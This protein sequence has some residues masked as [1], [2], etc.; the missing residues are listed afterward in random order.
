MA[1]G[2]ARRAAVMVGKPFADV[3]PWAAP[4]RGILRAGIGAC[5][6]VLQRGC[7]WGALM[8]A[9]HARARRRDPCGDA[10]GWPEPGQTVNL[11]WIILHMIQE[12]AGTPGTSTPRGKFSTAAPA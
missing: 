6:P 5:L 3:T 10:W 8:V 1:Q 9:G 12:T 2:N 11:R 7:L 4:E